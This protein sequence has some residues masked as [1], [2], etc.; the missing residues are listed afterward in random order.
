[1]AEFSTLARPYAKAAFECA[2]ANGDLES[3]SEALAWLAQLVEDAQLSA[4]LRSP[5]VGRAQR[6]ELLME[7]GGDRLPAL[8]RNFVQVLAS[9]DRLLLLPVIFAQFQALKADHQRLVEV[10]VTSAAPLDEGQQQRLAAALVRRLGREVR[11]QVS[12]DPGLIGGAIIRAGDTVIDG[13][14]RGR[15]NKLAGALLS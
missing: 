3:W 10:E 13:S 6:A 4:L 15:L 1:M 11:I 12:I 5:A 2:V 8:V 7:L 14:L 9:N